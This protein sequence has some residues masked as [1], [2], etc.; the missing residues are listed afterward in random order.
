MEGD[1]IVINFF[2]LV[3]MKETIL[4]LLLLLLFFYVKSIEFLKRST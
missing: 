4:A 2:A 3:L 1:F